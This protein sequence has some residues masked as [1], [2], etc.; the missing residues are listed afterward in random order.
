MCKYLYQSNKSKFTLQIKLL[1]AIQLLFGIG[2]GYYAENA[3]VSREKTEIIWSARSENNLYK[4]QLFGKNVIQ[5]IVSSPNNISWNTVLK[6]Y[7]GKIVETLK[8]QK[9]LYLSQ[10]PLLQKI[11]TTIKYS[12][13]IDF[14]SFLS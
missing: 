10:I 12:T 4:L 2:S 3:I 14:H 13:D 1:V 6:I 5:S 8:Q 9:L 11:F 7:E